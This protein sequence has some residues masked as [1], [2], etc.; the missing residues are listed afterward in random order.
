MKNKVAVVISRYY[1]NLKWIE[2]IKS[3]ID[4]Y[5][6]DRLGE[7]PGMGVSHALPWCKPKDPNDNLGGLDIEK[8]KQNGLNIEVINI[9]DDPGFEASTYA[10]HLYSKYDELNNITVF[11]QG[12]PDI[13]KKD[14][15][16]LLNNPE[17]I[18]HT[19]YSKNSQEECSPA[20]PT[21]IDEEIEI[22]PFSDT[23]VTL[24][25]AEDY[26]WRLYRDNY[27][28]IPWLEFCRSMPGSTIIN[29]G[30]WIPPV[31][32]WFGAGNQFI[33]N[34]KLV[35]KHQPDYYKRLQTFINTYMDPNGESRPSYQ[36][37]NQGPNIMEGI[38]RFIF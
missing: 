16:Y 18:T 25:S 35:H 24:Q 38:W 30:R 13:Y 9:P 34:K 22:E 7:S 33:V 20:I 31:N 12:H 5:I 19:T 8:C 26:Q 29:D 6:Y 11:M 23:L 14:A 10:Y 36:Q 4:V 1:E 28:K 27:N 2:Q 21:I 3:N 37:L 32:W 17:L 15:I